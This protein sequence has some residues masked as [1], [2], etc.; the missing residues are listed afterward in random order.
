[1]IMVAHA[2]ACSHFQTITAIE[3][4]AYSKVK[5]SLFKEEWA[6]WESFTTRITNH[7]RSDTPMM[8]CPSYTPV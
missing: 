8:D 5:L 3:G 6:V 1:M 7:I 2:R 4:G